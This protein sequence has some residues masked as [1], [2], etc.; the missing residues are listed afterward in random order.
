MY[1]L[2]LILWILF[3]FVLAGFAYEVR[4]WE[5]LDGNQFEGR[6]LREMFGKL[7]VEG[8]NGNPKVFHLEEL[9]ELD[10]K[11]LRVR[12]PPKIKVEVTIESKQ[13]PDRPMFLV[14]EEETTDYQATV[15]IT[16]K[17]Q[18]PFTSRLKLET[19][20]VAEELQGSNRILLNRTEDEFLLPAVTKGAEVELKSQRAR[21][22]VFRG[23]MSRALKGEDFE[24]YLVAVST[25]QDE[26]I[27][28]KSNLP[29]WAETPEVIK[30]LR[31]LSIRGAPS[32][33]SR[34]FDKTGRKVPPPRPSP[35]API[36]Q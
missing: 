17:S 8:T 3:S 14:A 31:E 33:R 7:T 1:N 4:A 12:V 13:I 5:D 27:L 16:K 28:I 21:T 9:S 36:A 34:H 32:V 22:E 19:F 26:I 15:R 18:R 20:L 6:F 30:N 25:L 35:C 11:Y 10:Q 23:V 29:S 24:G 2:R